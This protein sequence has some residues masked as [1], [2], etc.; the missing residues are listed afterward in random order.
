MALGPGSVDL[1]SGDYALS[2]TDVS[3]GSGL[4][5]SRAYSSRA[6]EEG[7]EGPLGPQWNM[8]VGGSAESLVELVDHSM[9]LTGNNGRQTIFAKTETTTYESPTGD[10][11]LKLKLEENKETKAKEAFYLE[12]SADHT[13]VKFTLPSGGTKVWVPTKQEGAVAT[14]TVTYSYQ[15]VE[16]STEYPLPSGSQPE[17]IAAGPDGRLWFAD[18][19]TSKIGKITTSGVVTEYALLEGSRPHAIT[20]GPDGNLWFTQEKIEKIGKITP[21]GAITEYPLPAES[22]AAE[23]ALGPDKNLWFTSTR[24]KIGKMTTAGVVT[25]YQLPEGSA[26]SGIT[27]GPDGNLWF[28]EEG[29]HKVGK[30]TTSGVITEYVHT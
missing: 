15:T 9:M 5:V 22:G 10:S 7:D 13:K 26:P 29:T 27:A 11:N 18:E 23:I 12:D 28:T 21:N 16:Q 20:A 17:G 8:T 24:S 3:M 25:L 2:A 6:L 19:S 4:T 14:D 1:E 30:I